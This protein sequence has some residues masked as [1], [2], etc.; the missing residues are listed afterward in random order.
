M[1]TN[2][3]VKYVL[4]ARPK[5]VAIKVFLFVTIFLLLSSQAS[6][7][8]KIKDFGSKL[9]L[10]SRV[11]Y[12]WTLAHHLEMQNFRKHY[13]AYEISL[14][15]ETFGNT[16]WEY[17]YG[18]P[19]IGISYWYAGFG[20]V[21]TLGQAHAV[22]PYI[23]FPLAGTQPL[24]FNFRLGV[25]LGYLTKKFDRTEN[26]KNLSIGSH[27]N[28]AVNLLFELRWE[29]GKRWMISGGLSL[30]H[31][32]N[33]TIK[34]P[35]YGA[36][37]PTLNLAVAYRFAD[38]DKYGKKKLLPELYPFEFDGKKAL[39]LDISIAMAT[40]DMQSVLGQGNR[41]MVYT[42]FANLFRP[43]SYK[44][45]LGIGLDICYDGSDEKVLELRNEVPGPLIKVMKT[46]LTAAFELSF[47]KMAMVFNVGAYITGQDRSEGDVYEKFALKYYFSDRL[48]ANFT[49]KA[50]FARADFV[51]LGIGY[52][53]NLH[54]Y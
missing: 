47:S 51:A 6:A 10:E 13:P 41:Y 52:K 35:N 43:V 40:K 25:G 18:Y 19:L 2:K 4:P 26:Y 32:S 46:G 12:G 45:K 30:V 27:L 9:I 14:L 8:E 24:T 53:F 39:Q 31:F 37:M 33:G 20:G 38:K 1:S 50:H 54:Y 17:M 29:R 7:Q 36:N 49:L 23:N 5:A 21:E 42:L 16:R 15:K 44:S 48:F 28:G 3:K 22:F 34:T 11:Y